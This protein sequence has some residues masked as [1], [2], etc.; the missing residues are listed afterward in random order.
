MDKYVDKTKYMWIK[1]C[2]K[3]YKNILSEN[4]QELRKIKQITLKFNQITNTQ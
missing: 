3:E 4:I 1:T 2:V